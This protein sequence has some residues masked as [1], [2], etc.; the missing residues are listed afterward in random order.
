LPFFVT[1]PMLAQQEGRPEWVEGPEPRPCRA[2]ALVLWWE[3]ERVRALEHVAA[4]QRS[5][6]VA[7]GVGEQVERP[8]APAG[9]S[10]RCLG[11]GGR[12]GS[13]L[14]W[15]RR[16]LGPRRSHGSVVCLRAG[17]SDTQTVDGTLEH[18]APRRP[19]CGDLR[20]GASLLLSI[21]GLKRHNPCRAV[22]SASW[23]AAERRPACGVPERFRASR[24]EEGVSQIELD[25]L[26][27][28]GGR[29]FV[30]PRRQPA[31][32][33]RQR[34]FYSRARTWGKRVVVLNPTV[35]GSYHAR[36]LA[37]TVNN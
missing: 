17:P 25:H 18:F 21:E 33:R 23:P 14:Q 3:R 4:W 37:D 12:Q 15:Q 10:L 20:P 35:F 8:G 28:L 22:E 6:A 29:S 13:L 27:A 30:E 32:Y 36:T 11:M 16:T 24:S 7:E 34:Q 5:R 1:S 31:S 9:V 2:L 26:G 19:S